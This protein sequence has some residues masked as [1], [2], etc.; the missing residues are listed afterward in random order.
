MT[1]TVVYENCPNNSD[2]IKAGVIIACCDGDIMAERDLAV[3][4]LISRNELLREVLRV[5]GELYGDLWERIEKA[6][7][8]P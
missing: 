6:L 1:T 7:N 3:E 8:E 2:L 4:K 5:S